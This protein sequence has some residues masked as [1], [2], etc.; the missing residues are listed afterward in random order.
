[1][2]HQHAHLNDSQVTAIL[3][4]LVRL[5]PKEK[6]IKRDGRHDVY[7]EPAFEIVHGDLAGVA[8]NLVVFVHVGR[9]EVDEDVDDKHDVDDQVDNS[10]RF[11]V[12]TLR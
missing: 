2:L 7:Q 8:H 4:H 6:E 9:A 12:P 10:H 3:T 11:S 1:M 5:G